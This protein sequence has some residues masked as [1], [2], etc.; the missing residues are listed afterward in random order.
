MGLLVDAMN[1][2]KR[3]ARVMGISKRLDRQRSTIL[4]RLGVIIGHRSSTTPVSGFL[5]AIAVCGVFSSCSNRFDPSAYP[6]TEALL[7]A[8]VAAYNRGDCGDAEIGLQSLTYDLPLRDPRRAGVRFYLAECQFKDKR[9]LEAAREFQRVADEHA[10]DTLAPVA[11]LRAGDSNAR[12]WRRSELDA[13][14][15]LT[16]LT[17]YSSLL[18][19]YPTGATAEEARGRIVELNE[20]FAKKAYDTGNY[21]MRRD[22]FDPAILYFKGLVADFPQTSYASEALLQLVE[23][24]DKIGYREDKRD[25]CL[26]LERY[27]TDAFQ[28]ATSCESDTTSN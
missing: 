7:E 23:A 25:M 1:E 27:Y 17:V 26:Q 21:Y 6:S 5:I 2:L 15:G 20:M 22:A 11:L 4:S 3:E 13:T 8:S 9:Y 16:A 12:M 14:Y 24:Y 28:R 10:Q 19:R 18:T